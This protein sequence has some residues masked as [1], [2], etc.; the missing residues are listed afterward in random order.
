MRSCLVHLK[1]ICFESEKLGFHNGGTD[2]GV[3][4]SHLHRNGEPIIALGKL[5]VPNW[6]P[7][8]LVDISNSLLDVNRRHEWDHDIQSCVRLN[9][10]EI[11]NFELLMKTYASFKGRLGFPG[12]DFV[13][14]VYS[15][16]DRDSF[17]HITV[18]ADDDPTYLREGQKE[19]LVRGT[20]VLGGFCLRKVHGG[21]ELYMINQTDVKGG[22]V[23]P[24][25]ILDSVLKR[26]P[27]KLV[28]IKKFIMMS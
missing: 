19:R 20:T 9:T 27:C 16:I 15:V 11:G 14:H 28:A 25:W 12:R 6:H 21:T 13:W 3:V 2:S 23:I 18:S 17:F 7:I 26:S 22:R 10:C 4:L 5:F 24:H 8:N 1:K